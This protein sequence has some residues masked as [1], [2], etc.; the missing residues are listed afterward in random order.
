MERS[1]NDIEFEFHQQSYATLTFYPNFISQGG[2][3]IHERGWLKFSWEAGKDVTFIL[4]EKNAHLER[5]VVYN[6]VS[7]G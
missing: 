6:N 3:S 2:D 4:R 1:G 7:S 5:K